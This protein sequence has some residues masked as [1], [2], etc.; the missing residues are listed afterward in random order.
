MEEKTQTKV[1]PHILLCYDG[2]LSSK[3]A[4][5][6]I[7][8]VFNDAE[9]EITVFQIIS[10]PESFFIPSESMLK[11]LEKE[12]FVEKELK[13][14]YKDAENKLLKL[15]E[16]IKSQL[17]AKIN[18]KILFKTR[19]IAEDIIS[20][21]EK[22]LFDGIVVGRRGLSKISIYIFGGVTH[23]LIN[24]SPVPVWIIRGEN[25]NKKF[26]IALDLGEIGL[27]ITDY[28]SFILKFLPNAQITFFHSFYPFA[29]L[30]NFEG[31]IESIIHKTKN[32][33]YKNFF[34][35]LKETLIL[36]QFPLEKIKLKFKR[37]IF[38]PAGEIIRL[39]KKEDYKT[40]ILGRRGKGGFKEL[41]LG[42]VTHKV[43][44]YFEDRTVWI[45]N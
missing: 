32:L 28:V 26:L 34:Q 16:K 25:W 8:N 11:Q 15:I 24:H 44:S 29:D 21:S 7:K 13:R 45:I 12:V 39:A 18:Y 41:V 17:K 22:G 33:E 10:P 4:I 30:K 6:Y 2:S 5:N 35:K 19:G 42:S 20:F 36:N 31:D 43:L 37:S 9:I 27:K 1:K 23:K 14:L 40:I 3:K 38:G